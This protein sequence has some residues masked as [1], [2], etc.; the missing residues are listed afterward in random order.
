MKSFQVLIAFAIFM[1]SIKVLVSPVGRR[2]QL[3]QGKFYLC[4]ATYPREFVYG[5]SNYH[6]TTVRGTLTGRKD[7][8][9]VMGA[10]MQVE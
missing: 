5:G 1:E 9:A 3:W 4:P 7:K 2:S 8:K 6:E 10:D